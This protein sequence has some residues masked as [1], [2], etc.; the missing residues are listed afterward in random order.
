MHHA[1]LTGA[2]PSPALLSALAHP[3]AAIQASLLTDALPI[4]PIRQALREAY[5]AARETDDS[6]G[7]AAALEAAATV[8]ARRS[9]LVER[10]LGDFF[11]NYPDLEQRIV[12]IV[13]GGAT[14]GD[15]EYRGIFG[16]IDFTVFTDSASPRELARV[17]EA[18]ATSFAWTGYPLSASGCNR[19]L[20]LHVFVQP[21]SRQ[22]DE[23]KRILPAG[24]PVPIGTH[25]PSRFVCDA[26]LRWIVNQMYYSGRPL[27]GLVE[28]ACHPRSI[29]PESAVTF[30]SDVTC[31]MGSALMRVAHE[32]QTGARH[33]DGDRLRERRV[34]S[35]ALEEAKHV[36]RLVDAWLIATPMGNAL[37]HDRFAG[38]R[39]ATRGTSYHE[40]IVRDALQVM[41]AGK[42]GGAL[43]EDDRQLLLDLV[44]LKMRKQHLTPWD[45]LGYSGAANDRAR[46]LALQMLDL[47]R[48]I[49]DELDL[50][51]QGRSPQA[52]R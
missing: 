23:D 17:S 1:L 3:R 30:A 44:E 35:A 49:G 6:Q 51:N 21:A 26:G 37:Y 18:L 9:A 29:P 45:Y 13:E 31:H 14:R 4:G 33:G 28:R 47:V 15:P 24:S 46:D 36:L 40:R 27:R 16:D 41:H 48:R 8:D 42:G 5:S 25:N 19:T 22:G 43:R 12:A 20:D 7:V 38:P 10:L 50:L 32:E 11:T 52:T 34:L 39:H 2:M